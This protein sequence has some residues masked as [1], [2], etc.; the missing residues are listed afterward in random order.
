MLTYV[1][2]PLNPAFVSSA[3]ANWPLSLKDLLCSPSSSFHPSS[4]EL[5]LEAEAATLAIVWAPGIWTHTFTFAQQVPELWVW[6]FWAAITKA[7]AS[8]VG[9]LNGASHPKVKMEGEH[10]LGVFSNTKNFDFYSGQWKRVRG[11]WEAVWQSHLK[12][13]YHLKGTCVRSSE[14]DLWVLCWEE[15]STTGRVRYFSWC[16]WAAPWPLIMMISATGRSEPN[17]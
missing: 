11:F 6:Y 4:P 15:G 16:S 2:L 13:T 9:C 17:V 3:K 5:E 10:L 12:G 1:F 8:E 7:C 14:R